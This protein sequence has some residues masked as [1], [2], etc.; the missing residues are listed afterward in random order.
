MENLSKLACQSVKVYGVTID[1]LKS[2][3]SYPRH[4]GSIHACGSLFV[5]AG[6]THMHEYL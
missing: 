5:H 1:I 4:I 3:K 6:E 2:D